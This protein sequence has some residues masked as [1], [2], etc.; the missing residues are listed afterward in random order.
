MTKQERDYLDGFK[1]SADGVAFCNGRLEDFLAYSQQCRVP[2][3]LGRFPL[4]SW[5][6]GRMDGNLVAL[7]LS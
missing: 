6:L 1:A 2:A 5:D 7:G 4:D 3:S